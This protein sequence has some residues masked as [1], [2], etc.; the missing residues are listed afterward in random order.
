MRSDARSPSSPRRDCRGARRALESASVDDAA[1][2]DMLDLAVRLAR[3]AG[4]EVLLPRL[5][6]GG[7]AP[8]GL[9]FKGVRDLVTEADRLAERLVV[10]GIRATYPDHAIVAEEE[11]K[12]EGRAADFRWYVDPLD[13]TTNFVH[14]LPYFC[15]SI[16]CRGPH[17]LE[18]A[19]IYAPHLD[20]CFFAAKGYGARLNTEALRLTVSAEGDLLRALLVTGFAYDQDRFP[21]LSVW[22]HLMARTQGVRRLGSAALDL[23]YTAAGR[24]EGFWESGLNPFDIAAGALIV[25]EAGGRVTDYWGADDWLEGRTIVATNGAVHE[26]LRREIEAARALAGELDRPPRRPAAGRPE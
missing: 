12:E 3:R 10:A 13:G 6:T 4:R 24:F 15:T 1:R 11:V 14:G 16:A 7:A 19:A 20:E 22:N 2:M 21:N 9:D 23:C 5:R 18:V 26:T 17:G 25:R 8:A